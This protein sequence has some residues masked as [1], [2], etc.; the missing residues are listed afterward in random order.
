MKRSI[1]IVNL[2]QAGVYGSLAAFLGLRWPPLYAILGLA[3]ALQVWAGLSLLLGRGT[4]WVRI[5]AIGCLLVVVFVLGLYVQVGAHAVLHFAQVGR[6]LG[7][8]L[9]GGVLLATPWLVAVPLWQLFSLGLGRRRAGGVA[10]AALLVLLLPSAIHALHQAPTTKYAAIDGAAALA[11][12]DAGWRGED[13]GSPPDKDGAVLAVVSLVESGKVV[14]SQVLDAGGL[15]AALE[16]WNPPTYRAGAALYLDVATAEHR[17]GVPWLAAR[18]AALLPAGEVGLRTDQAVVGSLELWRS[19]AVRRAEL[20]PSVNITALDLGRK[21]ARGALRAVRMRSWIG[22]DGGVSPVQRTWAA[23]PAV[24]AD[25]IRDAALAGA[26]MVAGNQNQDGRFAYIVKGPSGDLGRGYNYPRHAGTTWFLARAASRSGD[27]EL[28]R[29][30]RLGLDYLG[31]R[32]FSTADGRG[33]VLDPARDDG[34]S[35]VGTTALALL[36]ALEL[37]ERPDLQ[38]AWGAQVI[39]SVSE[40]GVVV[41]NFDIASETWPQQKRISY[42][43]GQGVL[44]VAAAAR[45]GVPDADRALERIARGWE[46]TYWP[47]PAGRLFTLGEH[48]SCSAALVAE[49]VLDKPVGWGVCE[50]YLYR[51]TFSVPEHGGPVRSVAG[52]AAGGAE[53][54]VAR[55]ERDRRLG[56]R[57]RW[58][59]DALAYGRL[60]LASAYRP[61]DS[62]L[63]GRPARLLGGFRD[64]PVR[65]DVQID[66]VQHIGCALLGIERLLRDEDTPGG[67]P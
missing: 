47:M 46:T 61:A 9:L 60:F 32:T 45:A 4:R 15:A 65:L 8:G 30:A 7:W 34:K 28:H 36:A 63:L 20:A 41:G 66:A 38:R 6:G 24:S 5:A 21:P 12:L 62:A 22:V 44:A 43:Q 48:W 49:E 39:S 56:Q 51:D 35:W 10:G 25:A 27:P 1:G 19:K 67:S 23:P 55:A 14:D 53:A 59:D 50:G 29:A 57:G 11:W 16:Q 42:A 18:G 52:A 40:Q 26:R 64:N 3:S 13:A 37:E 2:A 54:I 33:Y 58:Y 17:L 31:E